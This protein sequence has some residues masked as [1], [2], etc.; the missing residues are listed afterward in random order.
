MCLGLP[1]HYDVI[2]SRIYEMRRK[3]ES[4]DL[5]YRIRERRVAQCTIAGAQL[6]W[7]EFYKA[8]AAISGSH[9]TRIQRLATCR[10]E[11]D[12]IA[13]TVE[14]SALAQV[15]GCTAEELAAE[16]AERVVAV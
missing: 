8:V 9:W 10:R 16:A 1:H 7:G 15:I 6:N 2:T 14:L 13:T 11:S 12:L 3:L 4:K 5:K